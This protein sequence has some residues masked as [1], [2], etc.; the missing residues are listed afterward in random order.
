MPGASCTNLV[1]E[2]GPCSA[3]VRWRMLCGVRRSSHARASVLVVADI[4]LV[5]LFM[6]VVVRA[7]LLH[8]RGSV[9]VSRESC[10]VSP[11]WFAVA[12]CLCLRDSRPEY[13]QQPR[14]TKIDGI[15][16]AISTAST[17]RGFSA[18]R[19][20]RS[21]GTTRPDHVVVPFDWHPTRLAFLSCSMEAR[22]HQMIAGSHHRSTATRSTHVRRAARQGPTHETEAVRHTSR[23][24][25]DI[26]KRVK[27]VVRVT[28]GW[29]NGSDM[30]VCTAV[31][32]DG[33][34]E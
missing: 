12:A 23:L 33:V 16:Q 21:V 5:M 25:C 4:Q 3:M 15:A 22:M 11:M 9:T 26:C 17:G 31:N 24:G 2:A 1:G 19:A 18:L 14:T 30:H 7:R 29:N 10:M 8:V 32:R 34:H 6:L 27:R 28:D 13:N 20:S